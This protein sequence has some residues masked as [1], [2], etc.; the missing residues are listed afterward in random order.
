[1]HDVVVVRV[2]ER[3]ADLAGKL[4]YLL[5]IM[6]RPLAQV[7][8]VNQFHNKE[9]EA[10]VFANVVNADDVWMI[11]GGGR[12]CFAHEAAALI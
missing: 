6:R 5:K 10:L 3:R 4:D 9:R 8:T 1:M 7:R 11:Q 2:F 12:P